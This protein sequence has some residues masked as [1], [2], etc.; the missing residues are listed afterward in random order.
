MSLGPLKKKP[1]RKL[2]ADELKML[3]G[4]SMVRLPMEDMAVLL[5]MSKDWL[6][7]LYKKDAAVQSAIDGGRSNARGRVRKTLFS[8]AM[9]QKAQFNAKGELVDPA[10]TPDFQALKF[11]CQTQ[12]GFKTADKLEL[13][14]KDDSKLE[15]IVVQIVE[16]KTE[17]D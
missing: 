17:R 2:T 8:M 11:W 1:R 4:W 3:E 5:G 6:E 10:K 7:H 14:G 13:V 12:E 16:P 9:G 15:G